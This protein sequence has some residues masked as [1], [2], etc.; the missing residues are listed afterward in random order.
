[1][2]KIRDRD[3]DRNINRENNKE[4][5]EKT[6]TKKTREKEKEKIKIDYAIV[7]EG[8]DDVRA[9]GEACD[10]LIIP[11]HG[12]GISAETWRI[13]E[14]AYEEKG[15]ILLLDPD[16]AGERIRRKLSEKFPN[17][18]QAYLDR[19]DA[20]SGADIGVEN[21][22]PEVIAEALEKAIMR[23]DK[24]LRLAS[25][26]Q[27]EK[28]GE[29]AFADMGD[30]TELGLVGREGSSERRAKVCKALGIGYGNAAAM[31]KK[32]RGFGIDR[33]ELREAVKEIGE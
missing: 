21:A 9:V 27:D 5:K 3:R 17:A 22:A 31:I 1:M 30:L 11:T 6:K 2:G 29:K 7:V 19:G 8:R 32:L 16:H 33:N 15:L 4:A 25:L 20:R 26:V 18:V 14:K 13:M 24:I 23:A 12:F 28:K 10:A